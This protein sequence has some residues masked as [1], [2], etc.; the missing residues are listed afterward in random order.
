MQL[1]ISIVAA[2]ATAIATLGGLWIRYR[3]QV[4]G[5]AARIKTDLEIHKE[6]PDKSSSKDELL[7][8]I[9]KRVVTMLTDRSTR[10]RSAMNVGIGVFFA[11]PAA[12][13]TFIALSNRGWWLIALLPGL[14]CLAFALF[15]VID[16]L[17]K[18]ERDARGNRLTKTT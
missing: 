7:K 17:Q 15:G 3:E 18:V 14:F 8:D 13:L 10:Q 9:D 6:L 4:D 16:G 1:A 5:T 12:W 2:V 11:I